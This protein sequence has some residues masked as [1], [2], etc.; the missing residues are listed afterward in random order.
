MA[1]GDHP[2][3]AS[4]RFAKPEDAATI[5]R[6]VRELALFERQAEAVELTP[7]VL[8]AQLESAAPPF[9][10]LVAERGGQALGFALFFRTYS[11]WRGR[12]GMWLE[13]LFVLEEHRGQGIGK[14]LL[15]RLTEIAAQRGYARMEWSVLD[16]NQP[17]H[18]FYRSRGAGPL[19]EW[20]IWRLDNPGLAP[21]GAAR[22]RRRRGRGEQ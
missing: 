18:E 9:E 13:D 1:K 7:A 2:E 20:S 4:I 3:P 12:S 8:R 6:F 19:T 5:V 14:A 21:A 17:A 16:W 10:C 22:A 15:D 11:T